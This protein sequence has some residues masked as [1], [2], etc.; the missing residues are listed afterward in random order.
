LRDIHKAK[1]QL[2]AKRWFLE[3]LEREKTPLVSEG[4]QPTAS[5]LGFTGYK[6]HLTGLKLT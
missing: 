6:C 1:F 5:L 4:K 2:T 3:W